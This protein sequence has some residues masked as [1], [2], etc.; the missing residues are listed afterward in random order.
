MKLVKASKQL[1]E[2][3]LDFADELTGEDARWMSFIRQHGTDQFF[4]RL[5][6]HASGENLP[7][8]IVQQTVFWLVDEADQIHG[9]LRLRHRLND[10]LLQEGGH[11][12]YVIRTSSR[13]K[14]YGRL[15]LRLG[16]EKA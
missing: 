11:I 1:E 7:E 10:A 2:S 5:E 3:Y 13:R 12:G 9:E 15:I 16:L 8:G 4:A 6:H 14:G